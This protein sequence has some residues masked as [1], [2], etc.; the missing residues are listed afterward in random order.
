VKGF[1][2]STERYLFRPGGLWSIGVCRI[3]I[4]SAILIV[5]LKM[6]RAIF[7]DGSPEQFLHLLETGNFNPMGVVQLFAG[8]VPPEWLVLLASDA[9]IVAAAMSIVG[10]LTRP[11]M[12]VATVTTLFME[13]LFWSSSY[14]WSNPHVIIFLAALAFMFA[15]AN[16]SLSVD[17]LLAR[18]QGRAIADVPLSRH[19]LWWPVIFAQLTVC[20]FFFGAGFAKLM[21]SDFTLAWAFS[22]NLRHSIVYAWN[23]RGLAPTPLVKWILSDPLIYRGA[24][25]G[26]LA[27]QFLPILA[28]AALNR[29]NIRLL[30]GLVYAASV[31]GLGLVMGP[32]HQ[33]PLWLWLTALFVD[34][35]YYIFKAIGGRPPA[36]D[37]PL[38]AHTLARQRA[39][40]LAV[41]AWISTF[42]LFQ[43][44]SVIFNLQQT[45]KP[46]PFSSTRFFSSVR[47]LEPYDQHLHW[48]YVRGEFHALVD[49]TQWVH[50]P[51]P[52]RLARAER[53]QDLTKLESILRH[54][55]GS[56]RGRLRQQGHDSRQLRAYGI[57][58]TYWQIP[59]HPAQP[60]PFDA[61]S[62]F[63]GII[64]L[65]NDKL[66]AAS[67]EPQWDSATGRYRLVS[68]THGYEAP[69]INFLARESPFTAAGPL[70]LKPLAGEWETGVFVL[71]D[72]PDMIELFVLAKISESDGS[73]AWLF[74]AGRISG[75]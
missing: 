67:I 63:L 38:P 30:E 35:D 24:A 51:M 48:T 18:L 53:E 74:D 6:R 39:A 46:F 50:V 69:K 17:A 5:A 66:Y 42:T 13:S 16:A 29:P 23:V 21:A 75:R 33:Y 19:S 34:W 55:A 49:D 7:R 58:R 54:A 15:R 43:I 37:V 26:H 60:H 41:I 65:Q 12:L 31:A 64:D 72:L 57:T 1:L 20:L 71:D 62:G 32:H 3:A 61:H 40:H 44:S 73:R 22:D 28:L 45:L 11:S 10:L 47:A 70:P 52:Q 68:H 14:N 36:R 4:F 56:V 8:A 2:L 59:S 9:S 25:L 27:S